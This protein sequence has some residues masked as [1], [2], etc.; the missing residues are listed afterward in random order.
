ME[1]KDFIRLLHMLDSVE[2]ILFF[3]KGKRRISL[4]KDRLF[5]SAILREL[6]IIGEAAGRISAKTK[7]NFPQIPW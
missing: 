3:A 1:N 6:E 7:K 2:A 5:L 4:E